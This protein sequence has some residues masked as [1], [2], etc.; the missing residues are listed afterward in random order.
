MSF[1]CHYKITLVNGPIR[2][3]SA[4]VGVRR[5]CVFRSILYIY[6]RIGKHFIQQGFLADPAHV[7][8]HSII[9]IAPLGN[10]PRGIKL[11]GCTGKPQDH[12]KIIFIC[13]LGRNGKPALGFQWNIIGRI[14]SGVSVFI[15]INAEKG[16]VACVTW[17]HPVIGI[18]TKLSDRT[19]RRPHQTNI[20]V[21]LFDKHKILV[22]VEEWLNLNIGTS[23]IFQ[24]LFPHP[25]FGNAF[26]IGGRKEQDTVFVQR[27][28]PF[29]T[30]LHVIGYLLHLIYKSNRQSGIGKFFSLRHG[31]ESVFQVIMFQRTVVLYLSVAAMMIGQHQSLGRNHLT[32]ASATKLNNRVFYRCAIRIVN[33]IIS[34]FQSQFFHFGIFLL[35]Q[36]VQ[37]PHSFIS[38][39]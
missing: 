32:G 31:P 2:A 36:Q 38:R 18:G 1:F 20:G 3:D 21:Y 19:G 33:I 25:L 39:K 22:P 24:K 6:L 35:L 30:I 27:L 9:D 4:L 29:K 12:N 5:A 26:Q 8:T 11:I 10:F 14:R 23:V 15:S 34:Q 28:I 13:A 17:P 37:H 7:D 16:K